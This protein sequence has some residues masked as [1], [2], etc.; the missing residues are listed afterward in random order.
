VT[1]QQFH[2][3]VDGRV[4]RRPDGLPF[5]PLPGQ[6][7]LRAIRILLDDDGDLLVHRVPLIHDST[8]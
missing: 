6:A 1:V 3:L 2:Q 7:G 5:R 8:F 4:G